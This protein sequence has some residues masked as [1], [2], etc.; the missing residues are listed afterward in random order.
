VELVTHRELHFPHT[1]ADVWAAM[2]DVDSYRQWWPWLRSFEA[3]GLFAGDEWRCTVR[4]PLP[5]TVSFVITFAEVE[6]EQHV[7]ARVSGDI[8]GTAELTLHDANGACE[9]VVRSDL[10]PRS[11]FLRV[12]ATTLPPV[13][14]F[15]HDW[16]LSTGAAQ[17]EAK[18]LATSDV[19]DTTT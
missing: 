9:V 11:G 15:G 1:R 17:F 7:V 4:P 18:A 13:A 12:L 5:Y 6:S 10:Q 8:A 19:P 14:R 2:G 16:I 3:R